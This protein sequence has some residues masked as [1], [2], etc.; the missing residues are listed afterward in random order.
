LDQFNGPETSA[1]C[2]VSI[3]GS[4]LLLHLLSATLSGMVRSNQSVLTIMLACSQASSISLSSTLL[5][6]SAPSSEPT[7]VVQGVCITGVMVAVVGA[8]V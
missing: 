3:I 5:I 4:A 2:V 6:R 1:S 7:R 8:P